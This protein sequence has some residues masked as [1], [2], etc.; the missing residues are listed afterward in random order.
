MT[1]IEKLKELKE[2]L[3]HE[4]AH[5]RRARRHNDACFIPRSYVIFGYTKRDFFK[6][7]LLEAI[8]REKNEKVR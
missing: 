7:D 8:R 5:K 4:D 1:D 2:K 3:E 6:K